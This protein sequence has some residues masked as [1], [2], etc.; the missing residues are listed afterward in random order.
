MPSY[1][2]LQLPCRLFMQNFSSDKFEAKI[3]AQSQAVSTGKI[4]NKGDSWLKGM[5]SG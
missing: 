2:N 5:F 3:M 4:L 1:R